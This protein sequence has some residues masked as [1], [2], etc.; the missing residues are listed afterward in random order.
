MHWIIELEKGVYLDDG[1]G[2]PPRTCVREY[3]RRF[4]TLAAAHEALKDAR[5]YREF[6]DALIRRVQK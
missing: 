2:D 1:D 4:D 3:C 5:R 6:R